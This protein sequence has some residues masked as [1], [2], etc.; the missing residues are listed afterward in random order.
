MKAWLLPV[1][2]TAGLALAG[3]A[4]A[5]DDG[6]A[7]TP[8]MGWSTWYG[9]RCDFDAATLRQIADKIGETGLA[10]AG[11]RFMNVDDCWASAR[12]GN[13]Q[14]QAFP[15]RFPGG[16]KPVADHFHARGLKFGIYTSA[17]TTT[18]QRD[19]QANGERLPV[20]SRGHERQ[21]ARAFA[22]M[23]VDFVKVDWCGHYETQDARS[24]YESWR[25]AIA[26]TKRPMLLSICEWGGSRPWTWGKGV[27]HQWRIA[28][29]TLN[30]WACTTDWGGI[31][32]VTTFDR[33]AEVTQHGGP[34]GWNDPDNLMVGN[35]VLTLDEERAQMSIYAVAAA[36]L[37]IAADLRRLRPASLAILK[38][39]AVL[40]VNQD[41]LGKP[42]R[43]VRSENS[44]ELWV[45]ELSGGRVA[46]VLF[47][48]ADATRTLRL[49]W[50][51]LGLPLEARLGGTE[52][53]GGGAVSPTAGGLSRT[54]PAHGVAMFVLAPDGAAARV[55]PPV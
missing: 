42:G 4:R 39:R 28:M 38:D 45:R 2:L 9:V 26:A 7:R 51:E 47:N 34:G 53:W 21:D 17:G 24:S 16:M 52:L 6:Q 13:G 49:H 1:L 22:I 31:G 14:L 54:V 30:C 40:A 33:L 44:D 25:D 48:R 12:D 5:V 50:T 15:A 36:P 46:V 27:G 8:P 32:V 20:G 18:C 23:G 55:R 35:G 3:P 11:Y 41:V 43:R 29:D 10:D 19:L 37:I